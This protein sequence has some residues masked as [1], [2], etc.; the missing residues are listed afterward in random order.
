MIFM[1]ALGIIVVKRSL[2]P[3]AYLG[4]FYIALGLSLLASAL[5]NI[6]YWINY[7]KNLE[8]RQKD[9]AQNK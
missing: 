7:Q 9:N 1:I 5:F 6:Y 4:E 2:L 3:P 8:I